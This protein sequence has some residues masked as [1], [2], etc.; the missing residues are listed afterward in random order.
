MAVD[1]K[2]YNRIL[3]SALKVIQRSNNFFLVFGDPRSIAPENFCPVEFFCG[4]LPEK[5]SASVCRQL[6]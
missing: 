4:Q 2:Q 3:A 5:Q 1:N 6:C